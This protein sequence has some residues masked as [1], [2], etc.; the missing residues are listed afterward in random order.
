MSFVHGDRYGSIFILLQVDIQLFQHHSLKLF[1]F[2]HCIVLVPL[3][4]ISCLKVCG[5][6][7]RSSIRFHW[8]SCLFLCQYQ[9]VFSTVALQQ[10]LKSG[11]VMPPEVLLLYRIVL[12]ILGF[13]LF[14]MKFITVLLKSLKN[15]AGILMGIALNLQIAFGK[16]AIFTMLILPTQ[17]HERSFHF[18]VSS[19]ISFLKKI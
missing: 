8:S 17:E 16:I 15:F 5:L 11:T 3:S 10:S 7:S 18:L 19:S 4:K 6:I 13:L 12:A 14:H 2:F 1:S 9:A